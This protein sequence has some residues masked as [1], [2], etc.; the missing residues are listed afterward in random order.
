M[1]RGQNVS[2]LANLVGSLGIAGC[3]MIPNFGTPYQFQVGDRVPNY[4][5]SDTR[6][7]G[8]RVNLQELCDGDRP[9]L[10]YFFRKGD[11]RSERDFLGLMR[12]VES[13]PEDE[14]PNTI[15]IT[16]NDLGAIT[17]HYGP[18]GTII[19]DCAGDVVESF[20]GGK[21]SG[22]HYFVLDDMKVV[23]RGR[24]HPDF[25]TLE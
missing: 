19:D 16:A 9:V 7:F 17:K 10:L 25:K 3:S 1:T 12:G 22:S 5:F 8:K 13:L 24:G 20:I 6:D 4:S 23:G 18:N 11:I 15:V 14:R 2:L 21:S